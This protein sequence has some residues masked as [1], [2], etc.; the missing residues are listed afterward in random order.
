M[1][2]YLCKKFKK[3]ADGRQRYI[4]QY[5]TIK[6]VKNCNKLNSIGLNYA[7]IILK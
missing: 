7:K 3:E 5:I 6:Q 4:K 1:E 2:C